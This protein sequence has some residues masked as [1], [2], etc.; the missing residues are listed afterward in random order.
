MSQ[1]QRHNK[2]ENTIL[3]Y[4][5]CNNSVCDGGGGGGGGG[6][7]GGYGDQYNKP[8]SLIVTTVLNRTIGIAISVALILLI[9]MICNHFCY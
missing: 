8:S 4:R 2:G 1:G 6:G 9:V 3:A 5:L 7:R